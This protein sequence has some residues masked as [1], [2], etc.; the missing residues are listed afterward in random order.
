M[1][2]ALPS[3]TTSALFAPGEPGAGTLGGV[4]FDAPGILD[5]LRNPSA[6]PVVAQACSQ[7]TREQVNSVHHVVNTRGHVVVRSTAGSGKSKLLKV[8]AEV[9]PARQRIVAVALNVSIAREL[10]VS[11]PPDVH[12]STVH[13]LGSDRVRESCPTEAKFVL[14]KRKHIIDR[15]LKERGL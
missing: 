3:P 14:W 4:P 6:R 1:T 10:K 8:M 7:F 11:L 15:L 5:T 12:A 13:A 2:D 9:L